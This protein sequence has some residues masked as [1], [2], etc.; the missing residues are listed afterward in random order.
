MIVG[1][2]L[3]VGY[4]TQDLPPFESRKAFASFETL[5]LYF[6]TALFA[7]EGIALVLPLQNSMKD[8]RNFSR[9]LGVLNVGMVFV[10]SIYIIVGLIGYWKYGEETQGSLTLNLPTEDM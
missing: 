4:A 8:P 10:S 2:I 3:T 6:G 9:P 1:I 5:P 7:F